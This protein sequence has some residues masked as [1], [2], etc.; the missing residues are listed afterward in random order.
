MIIRSIEKGRKSKEWKRGNIVPI[1][2]G[3]KKTAS[4]SYRPVSLTSVVAKICEIVIKEK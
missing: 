2:K 4:V 3:G 1:C